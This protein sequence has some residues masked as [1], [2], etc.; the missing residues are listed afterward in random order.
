MNSVTDETINRSQI[1][2][3]KF[4][5]RLMEHLDKIELQG[6]LLEQIEK[7]EKELKDEQ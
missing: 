1:I 5:L 6:V 3:F 4:V 7:L 2:A